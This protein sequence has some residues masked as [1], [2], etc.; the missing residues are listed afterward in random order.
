MAVYNSRF[1]EVKDEAMLSI[2][3]R[4]H[5][6]EI[7]RYNRKVELAVRRAEYYLSTRRREWGMWNR[8]CMECLEMAAREFD[9]DANDV[10]S[11]LNSNER[12]NYQIQTFGR[13]L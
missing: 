7:E 3:I 2:P 6:S 12:Q 1:T 13:I 10:A 4:T 5:K 11:V 9:V 8:G